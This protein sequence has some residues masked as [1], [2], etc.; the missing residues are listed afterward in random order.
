[1]G[2]SKYSKAPISNQLIHHKSKL[3]SS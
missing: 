1:V 3:S 2:K